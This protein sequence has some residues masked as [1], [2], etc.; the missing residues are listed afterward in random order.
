M[1]QT[2][3]L[4]FF[5]GFFKGFHSTISS[6][7]FQKISLE[8]PYQNSAGHFKDFPKKKSS[9]VSFSNFFFRNSSK[10]SLFFKFLL[11]ILPSITLEILSWFSGK[12]TREIIGLNS[13]QSIWKKNMK[14]SVE[15]YLWGFL[16]EF[17]PT[18]S[19]EKEFFYE[20]LNF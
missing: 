9:K 14:G 2:Y 5:L 6:G 12:I 10:N 15:M 13:Q 19:Y 11:G 3:R 8:I 1:D 17:F 18:G 7:S 16:K 20:F 4:Y